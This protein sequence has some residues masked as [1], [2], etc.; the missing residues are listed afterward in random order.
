MNF[1]LLYCL[2]PINSIALTT[3]LISRVIT[4]CFLV[5]SQYFKDGMG[6]L[7]SHLNIR[8]LV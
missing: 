6:P 3:D 7:K 8:F 4:N 2:S 1:I 5:C